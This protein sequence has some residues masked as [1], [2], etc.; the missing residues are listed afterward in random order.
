MHMSVDTLIHMIMATSMEPAAHLLDATAMCTMCF[1]N[2]LRCVVRH[3]L[4]HVCRRVF[5]HVMRRVLKQ[6]CRDTG[7]RR[8]VLKPVCKH[9]F[10]HV[11][12]HVCA[13]VFG[14]VRG[15]VIQHMFTYVFRHVLGTCLPFAMGSWQRLLQTNNP[16]TTCS[17]LNWMIVS[18]SCSGERPP[19][20]A[21]LLCTDMCSDMLFRQVSGHVCVHTRWY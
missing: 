21:P 8:S 19:S 3:V 11:F 13:H 17:S 12:G 15:H 1:Q 9:V 5:R 18:I 6:L 20:M 14:H 2:L 4:K 16:K 7:Y 10:R